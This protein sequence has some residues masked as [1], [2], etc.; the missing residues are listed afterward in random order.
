M[1][2]KFVG[3]L[4][5]ELAVTMSLLFIEEVVEFLFGV[6]KVLI[7]STALHLAPEELFGFISA[8]GPTFVLIMFLENLL[9]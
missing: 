2:E 6:G 1:L 8:D 5:R 7:V 3:L 4:S 9:Y